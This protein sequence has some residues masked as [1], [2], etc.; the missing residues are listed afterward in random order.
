[1]PFPAVGVRCVNVYLLIIYSINRIPHGRTLRS[2]PGGLDARVK[3]R[4]HGIIGASFDG[5]GKLRH[6]KKDVTK[7]HVHFDSYLQCES[8][9]AFLG[10]TCDRA[11]VSLLDF[12]VDNPLRHSRGFY[13]AHHHHVCDS[14]D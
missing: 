3:Q 8:D 1:M 14:S 6:G 9:V 5:D 13:T 11:S 4:P 7:R 2:L 10:K 12:H